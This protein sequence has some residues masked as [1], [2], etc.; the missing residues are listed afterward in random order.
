[1]QHTPLW[2]PKFPI[3]GIKKARTKIGT[4]RIS[5]TKTALIWMTHSVFINIRVNYWALRW[6]AWR[7]RLCLKMWSE[8]NKGTIVRLDL[9]QVDLLASGAS[10]VWPWSGWSRATKSREVD[11]S[12]LMGSHLHF[13]PKMGGGMTRMWGFKFHLRVLDFNSRMCICIIEG[14]NLCES[15]LQQWF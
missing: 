1:M 14:A 9:L 2:R 5:H 12:R 8:V 3:L 6:I 15:C 10:L 7:E 4:L 13:V 11:L